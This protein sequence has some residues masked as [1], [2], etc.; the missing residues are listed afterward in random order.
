MFY[1]SEKGR[2]SIRAL[3]EERK[4]GY[5]TSRGIESYDTKINGGHDENPDTCKVL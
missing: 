1:D 5:H 2:Y 4:K 3:C